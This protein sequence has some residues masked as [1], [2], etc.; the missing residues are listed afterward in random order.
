MS[1]SPSAPATVSWPIATMMALLVPALV[2][3][4]FLLFAL[5]LSDTLSLAMAC[6]GWLAVG[7]LLFRIGQRRAR[8]WGLGLLA[9]ALACLPWALVPGLV[10]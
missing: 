7:G 3:W 9:G 6:I 8:S 4:T 5:G 2:F 10:T 1:D